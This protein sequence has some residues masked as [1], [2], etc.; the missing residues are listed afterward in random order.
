MKA[1]AK[2]PTAG[3]ATRTDGSVQPL[4]SLAA[5]IASGLEPCLL[6]QDMEQW[7]ADLQ[8]RLDRIQQH[9][10]QGLGFIEE[11]VRQCTLE[12]Q[13]KAVER[14]MQA[15][16]DAVDAICPCCQRALIEKKYRVP[17]T[18]DSYCGKLRLHRTH[19]WCKG[20]RQWVFPADAALGLCPDSTASLLVQE[21]SALL[22]TK[23][24]AEQ[25][26]A[27][28]GRIT[29]RK[30]SRSTLAR[31]AKR[32]GDRAIQLRQKQTTQPVF[33]PPKVQA[34]KAAI[35]LDQPWKPFT[36]VIQID[37][38]N[39]RERDE[40]GQTQAMHKRGQE[41]SRWHWVYTGTCFRLEQRIQKG[42]RRAL[43]T[44][45]SY[46]ATRAGIEP[47][48][49]QLH[50]EAMARGLAQ[51]QRVLVIADGALWIWNAVQDRFSEATQ[52]LD[53]FHANTY[54]WAVANQIHE[55]DSAAARQWVK[56]LLKQIRTDKV[57]KVIA[58]LD[59][60]KPALSSAAAKAAT[61]A[62]EYYQ[63]NQKRMK[64]VGGKR[65]G[66]PLGSGTIE[67]TC[68]Q[69][70]CRM[71]RCG[72]FWSTQGDE[73]LLCLEVFW[74]NE[75]WDLLFPHVVITASLHN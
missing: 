63:N 27:V 14:A 72:Q 35:G 2:L 73:A 56:P 66:E 5:Q 29:G 31:E 1:S 18:I 37:A 16:A 11:H 40:W 9:R 39:I 49:K 67:S 30:L 47:M 61:E 20:C 25:A 64:Y 48:I 26:E 24:P 75:R 12:L 52:R 15:K 13:R 44:E 36:M 22:V 57:A 10:E 51:A 70:Q 42:K 60:L 23:M 32:Q 6:P 58:Q 3:V 65:R 17:K 38:W 46:V 68:R 41:L 59:E 7:R 55:A 28:S 33:V 21:M 62:I 4:P 69:M 43:I 50:F 8:A 45:R 54:L 53:L 74:R 71:K 34:A 19:G